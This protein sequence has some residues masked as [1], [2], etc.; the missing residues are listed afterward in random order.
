MLTG[1]LKCD[2]CG[3]NFTMSGR[4]RNGK[5]EGRYRCSYN[6]NRGKSV[7]GNSRAV[8]QNKIETA[9]LKLVG[10]S[11]LSEDT[12][13]GIM[14]E[15]ATLAETELLEPEVGDLTPQ[16]REIEKEIRNLTSAIKVGGPIEQL[17]DELKACQGRKA[18]LE[19]K[20]KARNRPGDAVDIDW[21]IVTEAVKDL[22]RLFEVAEP[23]EKKELLSIFIRKIR[24]PR[25]GSALLE[26]NPEGLL[27]ATKL[28]HNSVVPLNGD[29]EGSRYVCDA[30]GGT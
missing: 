29:P 27:Q 19:E 24:I 22:Q 17:V 10:G 18:S 5:M 15:D 11:L 12:I 13:R 6:R 23:E 9:V 26:P 14:E 21:G 7:C 25:T 16:I 28:P 8:N 2:E 30:C 20:Q 1:L 4:N 3:A